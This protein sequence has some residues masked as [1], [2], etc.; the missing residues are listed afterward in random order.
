[1]IGQ[2]GP[3][4]MVTMA[5]KKGLTL[6]TPTRNNRGGTITTANEVTT[7]HKGR[8]PHAPERALI[9]A[10]HPGRMKSASPTEW[11]STTDEQR[12]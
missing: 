3:H 8:K 7:D 6:M 4:A 2:A 10:S 1:M 12:W 5:P 9:P 11:G